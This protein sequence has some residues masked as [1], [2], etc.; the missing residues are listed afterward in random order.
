M[1]R[2]DLARIGSR[3]NADGNAWKTT[4]HSLASQQSGPIGSDSCIEFVSGQLYSE[5]YN[6]AEPDDVEEFVKR[7]IEV[8]ELEDLSDVNKLL[9]RE[10]HERENFEGQLA[11]AS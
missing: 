8:Y 6:D 3:F 10:K 4:L 7:F 5:C 11:F 9:G 2:R 1:T